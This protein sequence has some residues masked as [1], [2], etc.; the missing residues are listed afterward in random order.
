M[1]LLLGALLVLLVLLQYEFW[2]SEGGIQ[3]V[4]QLQKDIAKQKAVNAQLEKQ[5]DAL[6]SNIHALKHD[7][8][9]IESR[10]RNELGMIKKGETFYQVVGDDKKVE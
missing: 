10:A 6:A 4:W 1:K 8:S 7:S 5:N 3:T 2:F 9:A